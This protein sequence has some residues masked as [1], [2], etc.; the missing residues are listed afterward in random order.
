MGYFN[1]LQLFGAC[2]ARSQAIKNGAEK[3]AFL[4]EN[5]MLVVNI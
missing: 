2:R 3:N 1:T 4:P 5:V